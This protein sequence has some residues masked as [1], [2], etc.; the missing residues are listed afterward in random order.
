MNSYIALPLCAICAG[1]VFISDYKRASGGKKIV[2]TDCCGVP[3]CFN[4]SGVD[5]FCLYCKKMTSTSMVWKTIYR[6]W[7]AKFLEF[8]KLES[9]TKEPFFSEFL[10]YSKR[11]L[12]CLAVQHIL[13][14]LRLY[15]SSVVIPSILK[16]FIQVRVPKSFIFRTPDDIQRCQR[17]YSVIKSKDF[18]KIYQDYFRQSEIVMRYS[19]KYYH[20][21]W[22][23]FIA[24]KLSTMLLPD[25]NAISRIVNRIT[26]NNAH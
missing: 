6:D 24:L 23:F 14:E 12:N 16:V 26:K 20:S 9:L 3:V 15:T 4:C 21:G 17:L 25:V 19:R 1:I 2:K 22:I 11:R 5:V 18:N 7:G 10:K 13:Q 8:K